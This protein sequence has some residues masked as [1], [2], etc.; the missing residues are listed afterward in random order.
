MYFKDMHRFRSSQAIVLLKHKKKSSYIIKSNSKLHWLI[1]TWFWN[2]IL[3][4][5]KNMYVCDMFYSLRKD[6]QRYFSSQEW[7]MGPKEEYVTQKSN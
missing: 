5:V 3:N 2:F 1:E 7:K 6:L 4:V